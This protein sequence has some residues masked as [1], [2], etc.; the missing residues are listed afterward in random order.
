MSK[1]LHNDIYRMLHLPTAVVSLDLKECYDAVNHAICSVGLQAFQVPILAIKL[2]LLVL[3]TMLLQRSHCGTLIAW[4]HVYTIS[5]STGGWTSA[6]LLHAYEA[7]MM[8]VGLGGNIFAWS[9]KKYGKLAEQSWFC[10]LWELY[11]K[12]KV[13]TSHMTSN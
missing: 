4:D 10:L 6:L 13:Q 9:Y 3:H 8:D 2:M 11:H 7:F 1:T 12:Y 5:T